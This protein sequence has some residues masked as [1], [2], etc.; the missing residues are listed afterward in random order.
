M[1]SGEWTA[2][3]QV[4]DDALLGVLAELNPTSLPLITRMDFGH[5]DPKLVLPIGVAV[6]IDRDGRKDALLESPTIWRSPLCVGS[7]ML[8]G[9]SAGSSSSTAGS[10]HASVPIQRWP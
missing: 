3:R 7:P 9:F 6:E 1:A 8:S 10:S 5:T 4:D 2:S